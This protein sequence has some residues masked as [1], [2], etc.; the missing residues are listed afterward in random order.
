MARKNTFLSAVLSISILFLVMPSTTTAQPL[1]NTLDNLAQDLAN[2]VA[3]LISVPLQFNFDDN[4]GPDDKGSRLTLNIQ[5][6]IPVE[7]NDEWNIISR[8][9]LPVIKQKDVY[10]GAGSKSGLGD[11]VQSLFFSPRPGPSGLIWGVGPVFLLPTATDDELGLDQW[12]AGPTGVILKQTGLWTFGGLANHIESFTGSGDN[13][14]SATFLNPFISRVFDGGWTL[15]LQ[16]EH[17]LEH[18]NNHDS[19]SA[20]VF[21]SKIV[22]LNGQL[23]S[24]GLVPR[25]WYKHSAN[26]PEGFSLR[27]T[28][29]FLFPR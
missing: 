26:S 3:E 19:G 23:V 21:I 9:I 1:D 13:D 2:P 4:I 20:S 18:E 24:F 29:V 5:P 11:T 22:P 15:G 6:V 12:G 8:T 10:P 7:L 27:M 28:M 16:A 14:I 25:Y 17:T